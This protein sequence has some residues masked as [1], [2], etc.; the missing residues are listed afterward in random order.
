MTNLTFIERIRK[1]KH[2][3]RIGYHRSL[4]VFLFLFLTKFLP[5]LDVNLPKSICFGFKRLT[6][7]YAPI[8][9]KGKIDIDRKI[10]P[11]VNIIKFIFIKFSYCSS[12]SIWT[13]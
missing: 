13:W 9:N 11:Y 5:F 10:S 4:F 1:L 3:K 2:L 6:V 12:T 7:I 8:I